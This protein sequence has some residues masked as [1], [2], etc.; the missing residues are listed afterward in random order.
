MVTG[1]DITRHKFAAMSIDN[2]WLQTYANK[3]LIIINESNQ[4]CVKSKNYRII[5]IFVPKSTPLGVMRNIALDIVPP[6]AIWTTW[7]DDDWRSHDYIQ[8]LSDALHFN[9]NKKYLMYCNRL[10]H[11]LITNFTW[12]CHIRSGTYIFFCYK[13]PELTYDEVENK[14]DII[15]KNLMYSRS[16]RLTIL[17]NNTHAIYIRFVHGTNT[18]QFVNNAK[19]EIKESK[20]SLIQLILDALIKSQGSNVTPIRIASIN[21]GEKTNESDASDNDIKY[22]NV[23]K[24]MYIK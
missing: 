19:N 24:K 2:F 21:L 7:D 10:E 6:N 13:D 22:V 5:E 20:S 11:N 14:E 18:S 16:E 23:V 17:S 9:D 1:K 8:I 12:R 3:Y 15:I 4:T